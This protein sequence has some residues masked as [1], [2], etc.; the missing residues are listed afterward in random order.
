MVNK[1]IRPNN[2]QEMH[3]FLALVK[4]DGGR[5]PTDL[6]IERY[7]WK[8]SIVANHFSENY[9]E[10]EFEHDGCYFISIFK[11]RMFVPF[12]K[13]E[14]YPNLF[15][16]AW[17]GICKW[18]FRDALYNDKESIDMQIYSNLNSCCQPN[19]SVN[20]VAWYGTKYSL[21]YL[22]FLMRGEFDR[23]VRLIPNGILQVETPLGVWTIANRVEQND[24]D[25]KYWAYDYDE[26]DKKIKEDLAKLNQQTA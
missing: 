10:L 20:E 21:V 24:D 17:V 6:F 15:P 5:D 19:F 8:N 7:G 9:T 11:T 4:L 12:I 2:P 23:R 13:F 25:A 3:N 22:K 1:K 26:V 14:D 16:D 18:C